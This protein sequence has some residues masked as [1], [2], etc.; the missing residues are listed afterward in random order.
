[1]VLDTLKLARRLA[2]AGMPTEQADGVAAAIAEGVAEQVAT[3]ADLGEVR[4]EIAGL[5]AELKTE[6]AEL[7][8]SVIQW[9]VGAVLLNW[10]AMAGLV[11][12]IWNLSHR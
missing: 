10:A 12:A 7:R 3:K 5:R 9:I 4:T 11:I 6:I 8:T 2:A 1:M